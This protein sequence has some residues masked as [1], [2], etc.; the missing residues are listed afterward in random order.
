MKHWLPYDQAT[1]LRLLRTDRSGLQDS[2]S[3][4]RTLWQLAKR[5]G[6]DPDRV[7]RRLVRPWRRLGAARRR[8][9]LR[10][11]RRTFTQPH[12]AVHMFFHPFHIDTLNRQWPRIFGVSV[13]ET[14]REMNSAHLSYLGVGVRHRGSAELVERDF[15]RLL[16]NIARQG[17]RRHEVLRSESR[18]ALV[19]NLGTMDGWLSYTPSG[20]RVNSSADARMV[21]ASSSITAVSSLHCRVSDDS[22]GFLTTTHP[23]Q[24]FASSAWTEGLSAP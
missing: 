23:Y 17:L 12:L 4:E 14:Y 24:P 10:R 15:R 20:L 8:V 13:A 1:M 19:A 3:D 22:A 21:T 7:L 6:L 11:A 16:R 2:L 5:R 18:R 9:M